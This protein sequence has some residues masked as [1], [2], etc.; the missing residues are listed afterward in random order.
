M[1]CCAIMLAVLLQQRHALS[2]TPH[3]TPARTYRSHQHLPPIPP[4]PSATTQPSPRLASGGGRPPGLIVDVSLPTPAGGF[5]NTPAIMAIPDILPSVRGAGQGGAGGSLFSPGTMLQISSLQTNT[6]PLPPVGAGSAEACLWTWVRG[7]RAW[8]P[9]MCVWRP[10]QPALLQG[11]HCETTQ[12]MWPWP[13]R[14]AVLD[15]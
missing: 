13:M 2:P 1:L 14:S 3:N 12:H 9:P 8:R 7:A 6:I 4:T 5:I 11:L 10:G 15:L